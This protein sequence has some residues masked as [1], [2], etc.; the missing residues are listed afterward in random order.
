VGS[1]EEGGEGGPSWKRQTH[2]H[3]GAGSAEAGQ[4]Q[5]TRVGPSEDT[6][7][8]VLPLVLERVGQ[9]GAVCYRVCKPWRREL[10][11]RGF[12]NRT[13]RLCAALAK[14]G[15]AQGRLET[16]AKQRLHASTGVER[17]FWSDATAF[18]MRGQKWRVR[19]WSL[20]EWLQGASQE[21]DESSLSRGGAG[22]A[23]VLLSCIAPEATP[24]SFSVLLPFLYCSITSKPRSIDGAG[25]PPPPPFLD[26]SRG[27]SWGYLKSHFSRDLVNFRD[28]C[29]QNGSKND[30]MAPRTTLG[31][32]HEGPR[33]VLP[34]PSFGRTL[35]LSSEWIKIQFMQ[36]GSTREL[37]K[38]A[39]AWAPLLEP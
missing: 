29:P 3:G 8:G 22:T 32:P 34:R 9:D 6:L 27:P 30:P 35:V 13:F 16:L 1:G 18:L 37:L 17:E 24:S 23:Q 28:E 14:G 38:G 7:H 31:C 19:S 21:P 20:H 26:C 33:V 39:H 10:E 15:G 36:K 11:A 2:V 5:W 12:C 4:V 25:S